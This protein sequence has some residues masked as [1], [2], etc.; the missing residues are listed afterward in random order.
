MKIDLPKGVMGF[1]E[2]GQVYAI[3]RDTYKFP[4]G[5]ETATVKW[6]SFDSI[7]IVMA[8]EYT[9]AVL[10]EASGLLGG[11]DGK[12]KF[13]FSATWRASFTDRGL[14]LKKDG[15]QPLST[16]N[17]GS[18]QI[19][20]SVSAEMEQSDPSDKKPFVELVVSPV[21]GYT[22]EGIE[23]GLAGGG[24]SGTKK[25]GGK[26][27]SALSMLKYR[28]NLDVTDRPAPQQPI[29]KIPNDLLEPDAVLFDN[30]KID[31]SKKSTA[32]LRKWASK[33]KDHAKGALRAVISLGEVPI[34]IQAYPAKAPGSKKETDQ[35][36]DSVK[37]LLKER[38]F[39][40]STTLKFDP[41]SHGK[42]KDDGKVEIWIDGSKATRA[43]EQL[44]T[45]K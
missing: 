13:G 6:N 37:D 36:L 26:N 3:G 45:G 44:L 11:Q 38:E 27:S 21:I 7:K 14:E 15:K 29:A 4:S 5:E 19:A 28:L 39:F 18:G 42:P 24:G 20:V 40:G 31:V 8:V 16:S 22:E 41:K 33:I 32:E 2:V 17:N 23:I 1:I 12:G 9:L 35:R 10:P 34:G 43:I 25:I 30:C